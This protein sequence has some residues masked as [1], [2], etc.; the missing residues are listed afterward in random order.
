MLCVALQKI[1]F[2]ERQLWIVRII[3]SFIIPESCPPF[4]V[5]TI[6]ILSTQG[7]LSAFYQLCF[8]PRGSRCTQRIRHL[9]PSNHP[10]LSSLFILSLE[11]SAF[12]SVPIADPGYWQKANLLLKAAG[13]IWLLQ[14]WRVTL[15]SLLQRDFTEQRSKRVPL[16]VSRWAREKLTSRWKAVKVL[17]R[18]WS[19]TYRKFCTMAAQCQALKINVIIW[20]LAIKSSFKKNDRA[21]SYNQHAYAYL[22]RARWRITVW[23]RPALCL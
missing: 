16:N 9:I 21:V 12:P 6:A 17:C 13:S 3:Y 19:E 2:L 11:T 15:P 7:L 5:N 1:Y 23:M 4:C 20:W 18:L 14:A 8:L 22:R 10:F